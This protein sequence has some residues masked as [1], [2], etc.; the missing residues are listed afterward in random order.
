MYSKTG[1][2]NT[3]HS[4]ITESSSIAAISYLGVQLFQYHLAR[5]F[6]SVPDGTATFQTKQ[7]LLLSSLQFLCLIDTK[8][9]A[10]QLDA[11]FIELAP[12]D[13]DRYRELQNGEAKLTAAIKSSRKR[14]SGGDVESSENN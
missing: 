5:Q 14:S 2:K 13:I 9:A 1:G 6:R 4:A 10:N 11:S 3:K 7:F 8:I 12:M